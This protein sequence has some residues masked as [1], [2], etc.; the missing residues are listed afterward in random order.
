MHPLFAKADR[1]SGALASVFQ[2]R[3]SRVGQLLMLFENDIHVQKQ[4]GVELSE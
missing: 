3:L 1:V 4:H 2:F